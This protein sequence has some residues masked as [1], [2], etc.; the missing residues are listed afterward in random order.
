MSRTRVPVVLPVLCLLAFV[1]VG[2]SGG[3]APAPSA[4]PSA[5]VAVALQPPPAEAAARLVLREWDERRA[6]AYAAGA[7]G[8]LR[9]LYVPGSAVGKADTRLM[10]AYVDRG[11][12]VRGMRMQVLALA[13]LRAS[14]SV[15][16]VRVTDRLVGVEARGPKGV[17]PLPRDSPSTRVVTLRLVDGVWRV[18]SVS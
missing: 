2:C 6:A 1:G 3:S 16:R 7:V 11:L 12:V 8:E 4:R 17:L 5:P 15:I 10:Q 14:P 13:V 18:A 9:S